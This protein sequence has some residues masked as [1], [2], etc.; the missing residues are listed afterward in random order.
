MYLGLELAREVPTEIEEFE[1]E[2][3]QAQRLYAER[4]ECH[5]GGAEWGRLQGKWML[6]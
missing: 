6:I 4:C 3:A 2:I 1:S 5:P